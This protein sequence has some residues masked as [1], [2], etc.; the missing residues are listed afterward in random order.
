M[1]N[2][3]TYNIKIRFSNFISKDLLEKMKIKIDGEK[4][5]DFRQFNV[6]SDTESKLIERN[7]TLTPATNYNLNL[8]YINENIKSFQFQTGH[9]LFNNNLILKLYNKNY[10]LF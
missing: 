4:K 7:L 10:R 3:S 1:N 2:D 8:L 6:E 5:S 9:K